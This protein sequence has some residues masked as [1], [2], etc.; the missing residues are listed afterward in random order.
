MYQYFANTVELVMAKWSWY[1]CVALPHTTSLTE[2]NLERVIIVTLYW[3]WKETHPQNYLPKNKQK[4]NIPPN[5]PPPP[6]LNDSTVGLGYAFSICFSFSSSSTKYP[7]KAMGIFC[8]AFHSKVINKRM[9][10]SLKCFQQNTFHIFTHW[11]KL[12]MGYRW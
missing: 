4:S 5:C 8:T 11:V 7:W 1:S 6:N 10:D 12:Q 3:K 2:T 9:C